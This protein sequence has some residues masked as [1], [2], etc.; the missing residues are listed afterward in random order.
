[1]DS[2]YTW[3]AL[4]DEIGKRV[5]QSQMAE[6]S[7]TA[8]EAAQRWDEYIKRRNNARDTKPSDLPDGVYSEIEWRVGAALIALKDM[9][10]IDYD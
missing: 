7:M 9:G 2:K 4:T 1:M 5:Y 3:A 8:D 10:L 6:G